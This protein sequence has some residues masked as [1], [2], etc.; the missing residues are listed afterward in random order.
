MV[1]QDL[2]AQQQ[3]ERW[4]PQTLPTP[5]HSTLLNTLAQATWT[6]PSAAQPPVLQK[7]SSLLPLASREWMDAVIEE[8][9]I[10]EAQEM[11][12]TPVASFSLPETR[13]LGDF[14]ERWRLSGELQTALADYADYDEFARLARGDLPLHLQLQIM[15]RF[16]RERGHE[17]SPAAQ[18]QLRLEISN[19][20]RLIFHHGS[21]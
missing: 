12:T 3:R 1:L 16:E 2:R 14:G 17:L 15:I 18:L 6:A 13:T 20:Q 8:R 19:L 7:P 5:A 21:S 4:I 11:L 10:K 9:R